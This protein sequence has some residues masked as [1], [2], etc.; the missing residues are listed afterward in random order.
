M[1]SWKSTFRFVDHLEN[2]GHLYATSMEQILSLVNDGKVGILCPQP[3]VGAAL[4]NW[5]FDFTFVLQNEFT[6]YHILRCYVLWSITILDNNVNVQYVILT[7]YFISNFYDM[8]SLM[9][10]HKM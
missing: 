3:Q 7:E 9:I 8:F 2:G 4:C 1:I 6:F 5:G 10:S